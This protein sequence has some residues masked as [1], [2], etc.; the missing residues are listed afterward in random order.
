[1]K[2]GGPLYPF[3]FLLVGEGLSGLVIITEEIDFY[4]EFR[5]D[6]SILVVSHLPYTND[7]LHVGDLTIEKLWSIKAIIKGIELGLGLQVN[8]FK[9]SLI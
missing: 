3:L 9:S 7:T 6:K 5:V 4:S 1:M 2:Q 8:F